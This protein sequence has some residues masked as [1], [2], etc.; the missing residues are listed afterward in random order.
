MLTLGGGL[1]TTVAVG[2]QVFSLGELGREDL[3]EIGALAALFWSPY[4]ALAFSVPLLGQRPLQAGLLL[5]GALAVTTWGVFWH[6]DVLWLRPSVMGQVLSP[7]LI[8]GNQWL[9]VIASAGL[10]ALFELVWR[11][12][13][14][15]K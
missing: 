11:L 6:L 9:A 4:L 7:V 15:T 2:Y 13:H 3:L 14:R 12:R 10:A 5:M 1:F 8:T